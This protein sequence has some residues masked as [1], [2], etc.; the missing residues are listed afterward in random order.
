MYVYHQSKEQVNS[1]GR[2]HT[3]DTRSQHK[4]VEDLL[5]CNVISTSPDEKN[6][7]LS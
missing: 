2:R 1:W 5:F 7:Q 3:G 4:K 6:D